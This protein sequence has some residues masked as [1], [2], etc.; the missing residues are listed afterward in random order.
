MIAHPGPAS[1]D[2]TPVT[3]VGAGANVPQNLSSK[4][5]AIGPLAKLNATKTGVK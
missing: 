5:G 1:S 3:A 4:P 2:W